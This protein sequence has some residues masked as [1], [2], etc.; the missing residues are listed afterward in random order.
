[1][2]TF[3]KATSDG[4][5]GL[6]DVEDDY[7]IDAYT[8]IVIDDGN[9][10]S[11][12]VTGRHLAMQIKSGKSYFKGKQTKN[13]WRFSSDADHLAY[14]YN[15]SLP[16]IIVLVDTT[17]TAYWQHIT[18]QTVRETR[19]GFRLEIP[20]AN[21]L[22]ASSFDALTAIAGTNL[23]LVERLPAM[24]PTLPPDSVRALSR[25]R[26]V[27]PLAAARLADRLSAGRTTP[28]FT[29]AALTT[30]MPSWLIGSPAAEDLWVAAGSYASEHGLDAEAA[31]AF[32]LA[33]KAGGPRA[34]RARA[35]AGLSLLFI[36]R[37][38]A[39]KHLYKAKRQGQA[40][41]ADVGL[42]AEG[43][44]EN[45]ARPLP[46]PD[47]IRN[48]TDRELDAEPTVLNFLAEI[49][50]RTGDLTTAINYRR[51]AVNS[52]RD[53][54]TKLQLE[55]ARTLLRRSVQDPLTARRDLR[56][57]LTLAQGAVAERRRW[58]GPSADALAVLIDVLH[59]SFEDAEA[60]TEA[61]PD[62][63]GGRARETESQTVQVASRGARSA[64]ISRNDVTWDYFM[65]VMPDGPRKRELL[66]QKRHLLMDENRD[67]EISEWRQLAAEAV[68]DE[69]AA[70]CVMH[71]ARLG[72]WTEQ[73][74]DL[75]DRSIL[76]DDEAELLRVLARSADVTDPTEL[77]NLANTSARAA[78][79]LVLKLGRSDI[80][81]AIAESRRLVNK[82]KTPELTLQLVELLQRTGAAR[83][84]QDLI[85]D[86]VRDP[87]F[88]TDIRLQLAYDLA[89]QRRR[90]GNYADAV[91]AA[92][93]G[94]EVADDPKLAWELITSLTLGGHVIQA[95]QALARYQPAPVTPTE[96][97]IWLRLHLGVDI[98]DAD[99]RTM[100]DMQAR[101]TDPELRSVAVTLLIREVLFSPTDPLQAFPSRLVS[102]VQELAR[103][104]EAGSVIGLRTIPND[105]D[106]M[107]AELERDQPDAAVVAKMLTD[108]RLGRTPLADLAH[109]VSRPY[110]AA[111]LQRPAGVLVAAD[112]GAALRHAGRSAA[113][114]AQ[115]AG[116]CVIDLSVLRLLAMLPSD[117]A[118]QLKAAVGP[119]TIPASAV[120]DASRTRDDMRSLAVASYTATLQ[121]D[122]TI[123]RTTL[124]AAQKAMLREYAEA[125]E[126]SASSLTVVP[127]Q[128]HATPT[129]HAIILAKQLQLPL[130]CDDS[131]ARQ[132]ARARQ[133]TTFS[134]ADLVMLLSATDQF[135]EKRVMLNLAAHYVVDLPL[136]GQDI[137]AVA[138]E[139][140]W[141]LGPAHTAVS[142]PGWW[143]NLDTEWRDEWYDVAN[144]ACA[145]SEQALLS[146]P[147][148]GLT[149]AIDYTG[150]SFATMRCQQ[151]LVLVLV[152]C[153]H[154]GLTVPGFLDRIA[155]DAN[156]G[157]MPK[158]EFVLRALTDELTRRAIPDAAAVAIS[159][160]PGVAL[161]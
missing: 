57:A 87:N 50:L 19:S 118:D 10:K 114:A 30:L 48:A 64:L 109:F 25:A 51:R 92:E 115:H 76:P 130:W 55:L 9:P 80:N 151:M 136:T 17:G 149:G 90:D 72:I 34:A 108:V 160:L 122:G 129:Q 77:R 107:R 85:F 84:A 157:I 137:A 155:E 36:D 133:V 73:A 27:D 142:R 86:V 104:I 124:T 1:M 8:E 66:A 4:S 49:A 71:L 98:T 96:V 110:G 45:D 15:Y 127:V 91:S 112:S 12:A 65:A 121:A 54:A 7:G 147:R 24:H 106:S 100:L 134:T 123:E 13:G 23:G 67:E 41:L 159:L 135:K 132:A 14:W 150:R 5:S 31:N 47:S 70:R 58:D 35:F 148:A 99:V 89:H 42:A 74:Q 144:A 44:P 26:E 128:P 141:E 154:N 88:G 131:A 56:E 16:V 61:L 119:L 21:V 94:I 38:Q 140:A 117:V 156:P 75:I 146:I 22:S 93:A 69:M 102:E 95:R 101:I 113:E 68:D 40:L 158:P 29:M 82:F 59:R 120:A 97:Q 161:I 52:S 32:L 103:E 60:V 18:T 28:G 20:R 33:A 143:R 79:E 83:D 139:F 153:H 126:H 62:I 111:L 46:I 81:T 63:E 37:P 105:D 39:N 152:A 43:V 78:V 125:I 116:G 3:S 2:Q 138:A 11:D 6:M 53:G 145:I